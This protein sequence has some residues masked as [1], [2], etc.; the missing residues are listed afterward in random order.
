M[1]GPRGVAVKSSR[2]ISPPK[3]VGS[4]TCDL[5]AAR[6]LSGHEPGLAGMKSVAGESDDKPGNL[7]DLRE[8]ADA[9]G[10]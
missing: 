8:A 4:V 9:C 10:A 6:N 1:G 7:G 2:P 5:C 3:A